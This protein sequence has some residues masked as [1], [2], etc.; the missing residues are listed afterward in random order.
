MDDLEK[1]GAS[2]N[3]LGLERRR[4]G[5]AYRPR[6]AAF[7][8]DDEVGYHQIKGD[9]L[10]VLRPGDVVFC[11]PG[12]IHWHGAAPDSKFAHITVNPEDNHAVIWYEFPEYAVSTIKYN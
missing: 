11:P 9:K 1:S 5:E 7:F 8:G 2:G 10:Q 12:F 6:R 4:D 3:T